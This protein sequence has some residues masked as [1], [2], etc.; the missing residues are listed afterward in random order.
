MDFLGPDRWQW[1]VPA[2]AP[3]GKATLAWSW[4]NKLGA[5]NEFCM[6]CAPVEHQGE[7]GDEST[8]ATLATLASLPDMFIANV[9]GITDCKD[10][11]DV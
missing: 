4:I 7:G 10:R 3:A 2:E 6:N 5:V 1:K 9:P 8:L 11:A